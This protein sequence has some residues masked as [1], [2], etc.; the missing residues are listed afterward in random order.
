MSYPPLYPP[1]HGE[2]S[3]AAWCRHTVRVCG[4]E[5]QPFHGVI[6]ET[7]KKAQKG[8]GGRAKG[9]VKEGTCYNCL[10]VS[11]PSCFTCLQ[12]AD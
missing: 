3:L 9:T 11:V 7:E 12:R 5:L 6:F 2:P 4:M 8:V 10:L 1:Q